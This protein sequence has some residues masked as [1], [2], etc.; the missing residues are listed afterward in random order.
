[1]IRRSVEDRQSKIAWEIVNNV[2]SREST[3]KARLK[4]ASKEERI[5]L[6]KEKIKVSNLKFF[7]S[8]EWAFHENHKQSTKHQIWTVYARR[9]RLSSNKRSK[10]G[11]L[12]GFMKSHQMYGKQGNSKTHYSH[13]RTPYITRLLKQINKKLHPPFPQ[14][15]WPRKS[16]DLPLLP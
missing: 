3:K 5:H 16:Q 8:Y 10:T 2:C 1:M 13:T 9:I 12:L 4:A 11:K 6:R 15:E 14:E 7:K